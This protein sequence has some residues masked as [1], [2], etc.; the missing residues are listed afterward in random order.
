MPAP[1]EE[2]MLKSACCCVS[3]SLWCKWPG[4]A[5]CEQD[6][7]CLCLKSETD[8][9]LVDINALFRM[10]QCT[11]VIYKMKRTLLTTPTTSTSTPLPGRCYYC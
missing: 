8:C 6:Y 1:R 11:C 3:N 7:T 4:C 9:K 5:S 10:Q 2:L